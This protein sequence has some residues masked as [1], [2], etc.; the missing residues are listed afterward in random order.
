M[1]DSHQA[2][3]ILQ[4]RIHL[5]SHVQLIAAGSTTGCAIITSPPTRA[6]RISSLVDSRSMRARVDKQA[7]WLPQF[8]ITYNPTE[9]LTLYSN[10]GCCYRLGRR[11]VLDR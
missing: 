8:A 1:E 9:K 10:Y 2:A 4:D 11:A 7:V 3:G 5:P 6:A